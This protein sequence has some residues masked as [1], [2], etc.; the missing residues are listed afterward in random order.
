MICHI[1][2]IIKFSIFLCF[3]IIYFYLIFLY[4]F[5]LLFFFNSIAINHAGFYFSL[6]NCFTFIMPFIAD[7][8]VWVFLIVEGCMVT[9]YCLHPLYLELWWRIVVS[10]PVKP[11]VLY[12]YIEEWIAGQGD[13]LL[14]NVLLKVLLWL[15]SNQRNRLAKLHATNFKTDTPLPC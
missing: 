12:F 5:F 13:Y 9:Y 6:L 3:K 10:L 2:S 4:I 15:N 1:F 8:S 14:D 7:Y 11:H